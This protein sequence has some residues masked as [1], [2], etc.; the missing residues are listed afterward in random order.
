M[1]PEDEKK[2][3]IKDPA[4]EE[5]DDVK[6]ALKNPKSHFLKSKMAKVAGLIAVLVTAAFMLISTPSQES[7]QSEHLPKQ[8]R[9]QSRRRH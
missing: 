6:D 4:K 1:P 8:S 3:E 5:G 7:N 2:E 9:I